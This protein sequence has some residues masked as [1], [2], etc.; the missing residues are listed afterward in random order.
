MD[1][2]EELCKVGDKLYRLSKNGITEVTV[3]EIEHYPHCVY[4]LSG[5]YD[6]CFNRAFGKTIFKTYEEANEA[7]RAKEKIIKKREL[8][9][10]YETELN[11]KFGLKDHRI[12]K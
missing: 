12:V 4:K 7:V 10:Q 8:L 9:K 5:C 11:E 6:S 1:S 2:C 3:L